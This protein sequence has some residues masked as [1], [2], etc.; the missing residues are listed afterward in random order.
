M[1]SRTFNWCLVGLLLL[2]STQSFSQKSKAQLE[3]EKQENLKKISETEKILK[4]TASEKTSSLGQLKAINHQIDVSEDLIKGINKEISMLNGEIGDLTIVTKAMES[5]LAQLKEEYADMIYNA[6]KANHGYS[7]ITFLFSAKT[8]NQLFL[9]LKY[10][11]QYSNARKRQ[12]AQIEKVRDALNGQKS[13]LLRKKEE[14]NKLLNSKIKENK[15]L[16]TLKGKQNNL[17]QDLSKKEKE[18]KR[19]L[20]ERKKSIEQLDKVIADIIKKE[21]EKSN[22][23][24]AANTIA[25]TAEG[26]VVSASFEENKN[27]LPWPVTSGFVSEKFGKHPHPVLKNIIVENQGVDI[28]TQKDASVNAVF[29]GTVATT[30]FVPGMN[31]V[32]IIQHGDYYTLYA[33]LKTVN[34][35]KGQVVNA[36]QNIGTVFT[37]KDGIS[38]LQFQVW[39]NNVKLD[40]EKW[41]QIK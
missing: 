21:I 32:V 1:S 25:L 38:E 28:Q 3:K 18:L 26:A 34:V 13:S 10:L 39:K 7:Q 22:A 17:I 11:E 9:R 8:F 36:K 33:K 29:T 5:D 37:N 20:T 40:P 2:V 16:N 19:E 27:K 24:K 15:N 6:Y 14:Q 23:G 35:K 4:E 41:L 31:S 12:V 30:A